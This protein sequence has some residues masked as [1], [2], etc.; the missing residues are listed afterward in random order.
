MA[1]RRT[2]SPTSP[3]GISSC[4]LEYRTPSA[5]TAALA[6]GAARRQS[7]RRAPT[8]HSKRRALQPHRA[9]R[10]VHLPRASADVR[11]TAGRPHVTLPVNGQTVTQR[12][13]HGIASRCDPAKRPRTHHAAGRSRARGIPRHRHHPAGEIMQPLSGSDRR[14]RNSPWQARHEP[15]SRHPRLIDFLCPR[16]AGSPCS[17]QP[18]SSSSECRRPRPA[19]SIGG[20]AQPR[21][22]LAGVSHSTL[23]GALALGRGGQ[24]RRASPACS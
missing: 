15:I 17:L 6:C 23:D 24:R 4:H 20:Q 8:A 16:E 19:S 9:T 14:R 7:R 22:V 10:N 5:A 12:L 11:H 21:S 1:R 13:I 18:A 3:S 2:W